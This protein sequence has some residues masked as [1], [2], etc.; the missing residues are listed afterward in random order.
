MSALKKLLKLAPVMALLCA[1]LSH[2]RDIATS[3]T[4]YFH[5]EPGSWVGGAI[6]APEVTWTHGDEG[7]FY[8]YS[9]A[10]FPGLVRIGYDAGSTWFDFNFAAP[11]Y[12]PVT[13]TNDGQPL[14]VGLY[15]RAQRYPF[16]SPT[17]PGLDVSGTGR[18]N[19]TL[20][21]WFNILELE[22]DDATGA[23]EAF[24]VDFLQYDEASG[25]TG[26]SLYGSLRFNSDIAI[27]P[28]PEPSTCAL[29]LGGLGVLALCAR[30]RQRVAA[31]SVA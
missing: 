4:V 8:S 24:A 29:M 26:P 18:G 20:Y 28:V 1:S 6:G 13:N 25:P 21:G 27:N 2:A 5:A 7:I 30:R 3:A 10:E 17:R 23:L 11:T 19:N 12:D 9:T 14:R 15:D 31:T 22:Y 16:N